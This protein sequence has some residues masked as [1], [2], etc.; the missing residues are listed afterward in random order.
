VKFLFIHV[1]KTAGSTIKSF[2]AST[3]GDVFLQANSMEQ[4]E[5]GDPLVGRIRDLDDIVRVLATHRGLA[6][7]V[8]SSFDETRRTTDFRSLAW[9]VFDPQARARLA[10]VTIL[11]MFRHPVQRF[12]SDYRFVRRMKDADPAF[13]PDLRLGAAAEYLEHHHSN[14]LLHFLLEPDLAR[15]RTMT[16]ADLEH[17]QTCL[18][19]CPIHVGL[20]ERFAESVRY[21]GRVLGRDFDADGVPTLNAA[22]ETTAVDPEL[23]RAFQARSP[24]DLELYDYAVQLFER[25]TSAYD[26]P[27]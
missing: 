26:G 10:G 15:R 27:R 2:L 13:L 12:L 19:D 21:F 4:L 7:H 6:L 5:R 8:D 20:Q 9:Y 1:P 14:P 11:T 16:R 25:R 23:E 3:V 18:A 24:L 22:P 17:V